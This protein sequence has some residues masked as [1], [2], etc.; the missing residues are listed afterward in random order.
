MTMPPLRSATIL[1]VL[2][3]LL[4]AP[5]RSEEGPPQSGAAREDAEA[6]STPAVTGTNAFVLDP[7]MVTANKREENVQ[8]VPASITP[9]S[10]T[11]I[12]DQRIE[13]IDDVFRY[14]P[15][16]YIT[17]T[18]SVP[19]GSTFGSVRGITSSMGGEPAMGV[20][21]DDVYY[22]GLSMT[23]LDAERVE[24]LRGPQGTL[25]G[26][27]TEA[28]AISVVS[29]APTDT[30]SAKA[31]ISYGSYNS[32][33][34]KGYL[35]GPIV[36]DRLYARA[37]VRASSS[38]NYFTN[39]FNNNDTA[40]RYDMFDGRTSLIATPSDD[41][42]ATLTVDGQSYWGSWAEFAPLSSANPRKDVDMD[43]DGTIR[44]KAFTGS[45]KLEKD[46]ASTRL[47]SITAARKD[48]STFDNDI[49]FLPIDIMRLRNEND[50]LLYSQ[51]FR[52]LST[53]DSSPWQWLAGTY[54]FWGSN[55]YKNDM[56]MNYDNM[57]YSGMGIDTLRLNLDQKSA[58]AALFGQ[59]SYTFWNRLEL[60]AGLRYDFIRKKADYGQRMDSNPAAVLA[61]SGRETYGA[62]LPKFAAS[63]KVSDSFMPYAS[64]SRGFREGGFNQA[65]NIGKSY[66]SEFTWNYEAGIKSGW[67]GNRLT[68]NLA[69]FYI[70]W[71]DRQI[72]VR[73]G[74]MFYTDNAGKAESK[75][76]ELDLTAHP[77]DGLEL[78][79]SV[80]YT[81][82]KYKDYRPSDTENYAGS[83][84]VDSPEY[85][86]TLAASYRFGD[87]YYAG[88]SYNRIGKIY[89][90]SANTVSQN[91]YQTVDI[92]IGYEG[93]GYDVYLF[94]TNIFDETYFTRVTR[95]ALKSGWYGRPGTPQTFGLSVS[96]EF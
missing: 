78:T 83:K 30:P 40:G 13:T 61:G 73:R 28:G 41:L 16:I 3:C 39:R 71:T 90:D 52:L 84:V 22:P 79:G 21:V 15:N 92:K 46:F 77:I 45:L 24:V 80:G 70:D 25:Y 57:G 62:W 68:S 43:Y 49:D 42:K 14:A 58:G 59:T 50:A 34:F 26:R 93:D 94:G 85:T 20:Y 82:A 31:G 86:A 2:S 95:N 88:A 63:Y 37:A 81:N 75:G 27:N 72:E 55:D 54:G 65:E 69:L 87:G 60:T 6:A 51:E 17:R 1:A 11:Q 32:R 38:D 96:V 44:K 36:Q 29:K 66:E 8:N 18:S 53:D 47:L 23:L 7:L 91:A 89:Y 67:F 10:E 12:E 19:I 56:H 74:T 4:S 33:E 76:I 48:D 64:I 35:S 9:I 5:A